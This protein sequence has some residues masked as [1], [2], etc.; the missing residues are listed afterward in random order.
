[1]ARRVV[2][3]IGL[4]PMVLGCDPSPST[5]TCGSDGECG[6]GQQCI[7][8]RC[9]A[10]VDAGPGMDAGRVTTD[11]GGTGHR[12]LSS[13]EITPGDP[14]VHTMN[15]AS[16][17]LDLD[18]VAHFDDGSSSPVADAFW[19]VASTLLGSI[20]ESTGVFTADGSLAGTVDVTASA[21]GTMA[22]ATLTVDV[23]HEI[24]ADGAP[25]DAAS[26]FTATPVDDAAREA[27]LLYPLGG[28]V[29]PEN[30]YP[31]DVQ[32][33]RGADGDLYRVR[34]SV[35]GVTVNAYVAHSGASFRYDWLVDRTAWRALAESAPETDV[36]VAVDRYE[37]ATGDVIAG[38]PR[39][40][41]FADAV[42]RGAIYYWDL[43]AGRIVRIGGDGSGLESFMPSPP[44][45]P[46]DGHRCVACHTVSRDGRRMAAELWDGGD[47]GAVFDLTVDL[48]PDPAPTLVPPTQQRFLSAS[49]NPD[50]SRLIA[51]YGN[52]LF[53]MDGN[54]GA[55]IT[56]GG[57]ALPTAG[58][59]HPTWSPDGSAIA[60]VSGTNGSWAVDFTAGDL[61][62][63]DAMPGDSFGPSRVILSGAPLA[64]AHPSWSPDSQWIAFQH[65]EH[66]R[67]FQ[68]P[69]GG[70]PHI[71]RPGIVRM[72]S[73][74]G[75]TPFDLEALN[76][77]DRNSY[78]P[79]FSP[80]DEGGYFWLAFLSTRDYGNAQ[81]GTRGSG[82][83]QL[84]VAAISSSPSAG[85]DPSHA[86]YWLPQQDVSS[87]NMAAFW[88]PEPCRADGRSCAAS[89]ECC[90]GFCR[91][92]GSGAVC[93]PP[94]EVP[95]SME[96]EA[97]G[98]DSDCCAGAGSCVS[99][100][101]THLM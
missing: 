43:G 91:D 80:F 20:D 71:P 10:R 28:A 67:A 31:P 47:Y 6:A 36:T 69:G 26:H 32:W 52:Y 11:G 77:G 39:T 8:G 18:L 38:T 29:F 97:C 7:D 48:T 101:C 81:A 78:Y 2:F 9:R 87:E 57:T 92:G 41:R 5:G 95:C 24:L 51:N 63:I 64:V 35:T 22:T 58:A 54:T 50:S 90:S 62:L 15:G 37:A 84:W 40:F 79:T 25:S 23:T 42:I 86:P 30:V 89:G 56:E 72:V 74:D 16:A 17:D 98:S 96:G 12:T 14:V 53:L 88:A 55:R 21:F 73:R 1:M 44:P 100:R 60:Y 70:A 61:S 65:G 34:F 45:R 13:L 76:S 19:S 85:T 33:E 4:L 3:L 93:V 49:F 46:S 83:R 66:S 94:T 82:R 99:N 68:D 27:N 75:A 59:A